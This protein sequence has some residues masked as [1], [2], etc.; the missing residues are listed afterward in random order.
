MS[1]KY[2]MRRQ[3][4]DVKAKS[5]PNEKELGVVD[6]LVDLVFE[7]L[8]DFDSENLAGSLT[9]DDQQA[10][11]DLGSSSELID[12][13]INRAKQEEDAAKSAA[14]T[15]FRA[16]SQE[17]TRGKRVTVTARDPDF[18][19]LMF[20]LDACKRDDHLSYRYDYRKMK[21]IGSGGQG[22]VYL[23]HC[24]D[25]HHLPK[26]VKIFSP[27]PY[28]SV[29]D[30]YDDMDRM[31][32]IAS[33]VYR[34]QV[35]N[36]VMVDR[37][38]YHHDICLMVMRWIEGH[39]LATLLRPELMERLRYKVDDERWE[40]L[41]SSVITTQGTIQ[42][43]LKPGMAVNIIEKCLRA[44]DALH[45][46]G[47]VHGDI[48][49]SNI[50][51]DRYGG[52]RLIDIGS[53]FAQDEP[54][55]RHTWT[56]RYAPPEIFEGDAWTPQSDL[57]SL[58]YVLIE[59]LSGQPAVSGPVLDSDSTRMLGTEWDRH[60]L[61]EKL[62]LPNRLDELV[63]KQFQKSKELM[64]LLRKL[65]DP[66]PE[67]RFANAEDALIG[68]DGTHPFMQ[69]LTRGGLGAPFCQLIKHWL[70]DANKM[71]PEA[72]QTVTYDSPSIRTPRR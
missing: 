56:P 50:M 58:G 5:S 52:I 70:S 45:S 44:L 16:P 51:L 53:A 1:N 17:E 13:I 47:I 37:F 72:S 31:G 60:L 43:R 62:H 2:P 49:P 65:I 34:M 68:K 28:D 30:Y 46:E 8:L 10:M 41:N 14:E 39:D 66:D 61:A 71:L 25:E 18:D 6:Q 26:A 3:S 64:T 24:V 55:H 4:S 29:S 9:D 59:L 20:Q 32:K 54:P 69:T 67:K 21:V 7:P 40:H 38:T 19:R 27:E 22:I 33:L 63:P 11:E 23:T 12:E 36:L 15:K 35:D 48:K 42:S 57:A